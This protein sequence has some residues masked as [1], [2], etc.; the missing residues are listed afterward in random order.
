MTRTDFLKAV[1]SKEIP[2]GTE[3]K[4][5]NGE[6]EIGILA[7]QRT[8]IVY[9]DMVSIP[10]DLLVNDEYTFIKLES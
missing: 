4:V 10:N 9:V 3:F 2:N 6:T 5:M 8:I 7:V 1:S